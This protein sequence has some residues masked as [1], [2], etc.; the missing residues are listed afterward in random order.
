MTRPRRRSLGIGTHPL[1]NAGDCGASPQCVPN[2]APRQR[3]FRTGA[4]RGSHGTCI[5]LPGDIWGD[6]S[7]ELAL[8]L[9]PLNT[10]VPKSN[11]PFTALSAGGANKHARP[12][13]ASCG[14]YHMVLLALTC[15]QTTG[16][17][18]KESENLGKSWKKLET[19]IEDQWVTGTLEGGKTS[20]LAP[21]YGYSCRGRGSNGRSG[22]EKEFKI[23]VLSRS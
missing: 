20:Y 2:R 18:W 11:L 14:W 15:H 5:M 3:C 1:G 13:P 17:S 12:R 22:L 8:P 7:I 9:R 6:L 21:Y 19:M 16:K 4:N 10:G 23:N